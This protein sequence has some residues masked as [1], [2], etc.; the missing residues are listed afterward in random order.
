MGPH[1]AAL[2]IP[3]RLPLVPVLPD[4]ACEAIVIVPARDEVAGITA[5]LAA[6]AAQTDRDGR[7]LDR[8]SYE[9][10]VL[11]NNCDDDTANVARGFARQHPGLA[12]HVI[13]RTLPAAE[14]NVGTARRLLMDEACR[15]LLALGR[16]RGV[17]A[18]TDADTRPD[19]TWLAATLR[20]IAGGAD[21]VGGR[22]TID[23]AGLAALDEGARRS[24]LRDVGYRFLVA[25]VESLLDPL[26]HDPWPRHY[27]HFGASFAVTADAY[28]QIGGLPEVAALEDV[29]LAIALDL[30]DAR[31]RHS[32]AVR[33]VTSARSS[34]H[35]AR[36][37]ASQL[38]EW[39]ALHVARM[40]LCVESP[41]SLVARVAERRQLRELWG[42]CRAGGSPGAA[43]LTALA[44]RLQIP[45]PRLG[46]QLR[47]AQTFGQVERAVRRRQG[48]RP[49]DPTGPLQPIDAATRDLR[50]LVAR[51]RRERP[52]PLPALE[53]VE[54]VRL[55]PLPAEVAQE[56][57]ATV[58]E[59]LVDLV[60][61]QRRIIDWRRPM[62][63]HE[64]AA[65][66]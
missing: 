36:G 25:E 41:P 44:P 51:L 49:F 11:A 60:A 4:P 2:A 1:L 30:A 10:I 23:A 29:A 40:P 53:E 66:G 57:V 50:A 27:Q 52:C 55:R 65:G 31:L 46:A 47:M 3:N 16:P 54:P 9:I 43:A 58:E 39:S 18:S 7:P 33:V 61:R 21:A 6:L 24:H 12:L 59:F 35:A 42:Q 56:V 64:L 14:A 28:R 17:I 8:R 63:Q 19:P 5:T 22:I 62:D 34:S 37:F 13:E 15:R 48:R 32:P 45:A 20:E 26:P 38:R